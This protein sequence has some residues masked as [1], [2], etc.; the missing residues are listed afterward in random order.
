MERISRT[1]KKR[2]A[3]L[4]QKLGERLVDLDDSALDAVSISEELR[5]AVV[6]AR[7]I[8]RHEARR[9]QLQYIGRLMRDAGA[10]P[11]D[12]QSAIERA[13]E[14]GGDEKRKFK[15]AE[16]WRDELLAGSHS[17]FEWL[18]EH[19]PQIDSARLRQLVRDAVAAKHRSGARKRSSRAL[20]RYLRALV[21]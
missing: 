1:Q 10:E 20:F 18:L 21:D 16:T 3:E 5:E 13:T 19:H 15:Q 14:S 6:Q 12:I 4:L 17:R 9:R 8:S 7:T 2:K 11:S